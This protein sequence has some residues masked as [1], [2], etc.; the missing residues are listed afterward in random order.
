MKKKVKNTLKE[1][2]VKN[3]NIK[4]GKASL[5]FSDKESMDKAV[6][7]LGDEYKVSVVTMCA[8]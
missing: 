8:S 3:V 2:P 5:H 1:V 4:D 7:A 6:S